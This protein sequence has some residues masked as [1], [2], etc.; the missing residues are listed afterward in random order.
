M[1][2]LPCI[3]HR[4]RHSRMTIPCSS[5]RDEAL[6]V[7]FRHGNQRHSQGL[8][9]KTTEQGK[10]KVLIRDPE[11]H[12]LWYFT[13][14]FLRYITLHRQFCWFPIPPSILKKCLSCLY[15]SRDSLKTGF[16]HKALQR[17]WNSYR[18]LQLY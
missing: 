15:V 11:Q 8:C 4:F 14:H 5:T 17:P 16:T 18:G 1:F 13:C 7:S 2:Y 9:D 12:F 6:N 10:R 3:V